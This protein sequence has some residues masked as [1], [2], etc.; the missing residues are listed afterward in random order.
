MTVD[1]GII[2]RNIYYMLTYAFQ[3]LRQ[4]NYDDI[5]GEE[6][7]NILDLFAEI[8]YK[9][10]SSQIKRGLH[11]SYISH[12]EEIPTVRGKIRVSDSIHLAIQRKK[13]MSCEFDT[14]TINNPHNRI[15]KSTLQ[16]LIKSNEVKADRR[17]KL[18]SLLVMLDEVDDIKLQNIR[19]SDIP[20]DR[21]STTYKMLHHFCYF[22]AKRLLLTTQNGPYKSINFDGELMSRL[23]EK[24]VLSY[25]KHHYPDVSA[26]SAKVEWNIDES[27][28]TLSLIPEMKT[29]IML[30]FPNRTLI[31]D[32]KYYTKIMQEY[33]GKT[34][35]RNEH[36]YQLNSYV[37]NEDKQ[38]SGTVDGILLYAKTEDV[39]LEDGQMAIS[40]GNMLYFRTLDLNQDFSGVRGQL[41]KLIEPYLQP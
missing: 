26:R 12:I 28:S 17:R 21:N 14:F 39:S 1:K 32:T 36:I 5:A 10:I 40:D 34:A 22:V 35:I 31:I 7:E 16:I 25:Y 27:Q 9:G 3:D 20:Y 29:D 11:K 15:L 23:F 8:L 6:F 4:N 13:R 37:L 33:L 2:I 41:D 38:H 18:R 19:W 24:F 30:S